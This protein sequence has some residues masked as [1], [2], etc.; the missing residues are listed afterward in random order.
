M[1]GFLPRSQYQ[2][3][4]C[5]KV[6]VSSPARTIPVPRLSALPGLNFS[7]W[8]ST[9]VPPLQAWIGCHRQALNFGR[10]GKQQRRE[11]PAVIKL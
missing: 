3:G 9:I 4:G 6:A 11:A 10:V 7:L 2:V 1:A 8:F 5:V